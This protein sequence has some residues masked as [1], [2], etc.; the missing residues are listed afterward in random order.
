[1]ILNTCALET[2]TEGKLV[3]DFVL[4]NVLFC[5][6]ITSNFINHVCCWLVYHFPSQMILGPNIYAFETN[7]KN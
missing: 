1:M 6:N 5:P 4:A 3:C 7:L 2:T